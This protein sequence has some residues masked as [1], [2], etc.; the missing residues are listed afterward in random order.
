MGKSTIKHNIIS[1]Y[2]PVDISDIL[3]TAPYWTCPADGYIVAYTIGNQNTAAGVYIKDTT[4]DYDVCGVY[5]NNLYDNTEM[6]CSGP[7]IKGHI[8]NRRYFAGKLYKVV[9]Y[10]YK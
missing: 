8:Y 3:I 4:L 2:E 10:Q 5:A 1:Y 7:V 6:T 9:Y